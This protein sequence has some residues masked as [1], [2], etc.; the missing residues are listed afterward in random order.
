MIPRENLL[1]RI[2]KVDSQGNV[3]SIFKKKGKRF[4]VQLSSLSDG[5]IKAG[6]TALSTGLLEITVAARFTC[7]H[8]QWGRVKYQEL[9]MLDYPLVQNNIIP[10][11]AKCLIPY[12]GGIHVGNLWAKNYKT[13]FEPNNKAAKEMHA[14]ISIFKPICSWY[15]LKAGI[16][17]MHSCENFGFMHVNG[18][19]GR[20]Q[21]CHVNVTW[22]GDNTVLLL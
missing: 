18:I 16:T 10:T 8:R 1:D 2:T 17:A 3:E 7:V 22:E 12:F 5:R 19:C 20:V 11:Y 6:L 15:Q 14:L 4:A 21:D 13:V 9:R